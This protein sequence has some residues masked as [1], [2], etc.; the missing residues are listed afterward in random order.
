MKKNY[1]SD[2][3]R[4]DIKDI[5]KWN[6]N[7]LLKNKSIN[8]IYKEISNDVDV[9]LNYKNNFFKNSTNLKNF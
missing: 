4:K 7:D 3:E 5:Y 8:Q 6:L 1:I 9:I 2:L